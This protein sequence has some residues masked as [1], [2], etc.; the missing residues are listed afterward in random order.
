MK[1]P[2]EGEKKPKQR[3]NSECATV[4]FKIAISTET[5]ERNSCQMRTAA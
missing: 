5:F 2:D 3:G 4:W 1:G